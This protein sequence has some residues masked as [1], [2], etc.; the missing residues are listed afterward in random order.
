MDALPDSFAN[1]KIA[2]RNVAAEHDA[3]RKHL[4]GQFVD[5]KVLH[6]IL[7]AHYFP[8]P[9]KRFAHGGVQ[10]R[11]TGTTAAKRASADRHPDLFTVACTNIRESTASF[12]KTGAPQLIDQDLVA[13]DGHGCFEWKHIPELSGI[14][15]TEAVHLLTS[16]YH[17]GDGPS[18]LK[19]TSLSKKCCKSSEI[20]TPE[21]SLV[22]HDRQTKVGGVALCRLSTLSCDVLQHSSMETR[23]LV[24]AS[25][26]SSMKTRMVVLA[27]YLRIWA[28][29]LKSR[30]VVDRA[31]FRYITQHRLRTLSL[32]ENLATRP[33]IH[34]FYMSES[35]LVPFLFGEAQEQRQQVA[36]PHNGSKRL[37]HQYLKRGR[38]SDTTNHGS[39]ILLQATGWLSGWSCSRF[40]QKPNSSN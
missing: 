24:P 2:Q 27:S 26:S 10:N 29:G 39:T 19:V 31:R 9:P 15:N 4:C 14:F 25:S 16:S 30:M 1:V 21:M 22:E 5:N 33:H 12:R 8:E 13:N 35:K 3:D 28:L 37:P 17:G 20:R 6:L 7:F 40:M 36:T 34:G 32:A 38:L 23:I 11:T 18:T